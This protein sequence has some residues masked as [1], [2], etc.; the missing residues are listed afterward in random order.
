MLRA[1]AQR[2]NNRKT[3]RRVGAKKHGADKLARG[4]LAWYDRNRRQLP[5]RAL[6]GQ[7]PDP[8]RVWLSEIMLQQTGIASVAPYYRRFVARWPS[9]RSLARAKLDDVLAAW[10]GLGYYARARNL[11]RCAKLVCA[12]LGGQFPQ[13]ETELRLLPGIGPYSA[14]AIAAIA[15]GKRAAAVDGNVERVMA[16]MFAVEIPLPEAKGAL[17]A[18]A[19]KLVPSTRAG[20]FAQAAMDLGATVCTPRNPKCALCPWRGACRAWARG[21]AEKLPRRAAKA[22]RPKRHAVAFLLTRGDGAIFLR[23]RADLGLLG[24]MMEIPS[25]PWRLRPWGVAEALAHAPCAGNWRS[26]P[27]AVSHGFTHFRFEAAVMRA[28]LS[29]GCGPKGGRWVQSRNLAK[30]A[31]PT[32]M[33]KI[34]AFGEG[35]TPKAEQKEARR[36]GERGGQ[37]IV[38]GGISTAVVQGRE[39][40]IDDVGARIAPD[41]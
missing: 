13:N 35:S 24:G 6:P 11:H 29:R 28:E 18:L 14:A 36:R 39:R 31:L 30:V 4:L 25:T 26:L 3:K 34:I 16:R 23:R 1:R 5:W 40:P 2:D 22:K 12:T 37:G 9:L 41:P 32:V 38:R 21:I 33:K 8:Y 20:D 7:P 19:A 10:Q 27:G 15:F 17:R